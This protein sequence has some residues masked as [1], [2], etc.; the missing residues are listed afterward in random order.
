[1]KAEFWHS[2]WERGEIGFHEG[3]PN[4]LLNKWFSTLNLIQGQ[5]VFLP[6]CGKTHDIHWLLDGGYQV[7]GI[8]LS[9]LA[10]DELF[11]NLSVEPTISE[12][13]NLLHYKSERIDI[14]VGDIFNL[15]AK[16]LGA[17]DAVYDRA[18]LVALPAETRSEYVAHLKEITKM[19]Q[20]L[21]IA[22]D[23]DQEKLQGPPFAVVESELQSLYSRD[24]SADSYRLEVLEKL[25]VEG[26]LKGVVD[27]LEIA[28]H[29][30]PKA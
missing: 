19:A 11:E 7:V 22:F 8:E 4:Q 9:Q 1:M 25:P 6:L 10:V 18:A 16:L 13:S 28:W 3:K 29:L 24:S 27:A 23:Y 5:R 15:T 30:S 14:F 20:Q 17:V 2:K 12:E 21:V 26:K